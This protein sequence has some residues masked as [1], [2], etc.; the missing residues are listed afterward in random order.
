MSIEY[1]TQWSASITVSNLHNPFQNANY[2]ALLTAKLFMIIINSVSSCSTKNGLCDN[3][4]S[5]G[6]KY[7]LKDLFSISQSYTFNVFVFCFPKQLKLIILHFFPDFWFNKM[8]QC[9]NNLSWTSLEKKPNFNRFAL[10]YLVL[11]WVLTLEQ[12]IH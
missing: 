8:L 1:N 2:D 9:L 11:Q 12:S 7:T 3:F 10:I 6:I 4:L 5:M